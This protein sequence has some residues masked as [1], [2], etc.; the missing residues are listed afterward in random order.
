LFKK[1]TDGVSNV[2]HFIPVMHAEYVSST[3]IFMAKVD[4]LNRTASDLSTKA[5]A[6]F[7][8]T[9]LHAIAGLFGNGGGGS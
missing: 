9:L 5:S 6:N 3:I 7:I 4:E 2:T 8:R 1:F